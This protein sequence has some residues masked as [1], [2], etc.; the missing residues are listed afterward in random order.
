MSVITTI[1]ITPSK[2]TPPTGIQGIFH[3]FCGT[4]ILGGRL[5]EIEV[6]GVVTLLCGCTTRRRGNLFP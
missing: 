6:G 4:G 3:N 2:T 1:V 5:V